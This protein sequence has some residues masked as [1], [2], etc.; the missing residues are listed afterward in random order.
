MRV[1]RTGGVGCANDPTCDCAT[2]SGMASGFNQFNQ[3]VTG[4][5]QDKGAFDASMSTITFPVPPGGM[6]D[7][8][9]NPS[10]AVALNVLSGN[11]LQP[12]IVGTDDGSGA[13]APAPSTGCSIITMVNQYPFVAL[14]GV[15]ILAFL[16]TKRGR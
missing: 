11:P 8:T 4:V 16:L 14:A 12:S 15:G 3:F 13:I 6:N 1:V 2:A 9:S 5:P 7:A 10:D